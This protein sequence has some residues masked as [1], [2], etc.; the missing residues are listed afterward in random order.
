MWNVVKIGILRHFVEILRTQR[1]FMLLLM[2]SNMTLCPALIVM[3]GKPDIEFL[4]RQTKLQS[5]GKEDS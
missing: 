1:Q 5:E 4:K 3:I 2:T